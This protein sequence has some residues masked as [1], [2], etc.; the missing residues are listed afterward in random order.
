[1]IVELGERIGTDKHSSHSHEQ[2]TLYNFTC[3][4]SKLFVSYA[5]L[6]R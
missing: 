6:K 5:D 3:S 4:S 2:K 1:M